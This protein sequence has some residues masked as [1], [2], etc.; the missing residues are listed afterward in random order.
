MDLMTLLAAVTF[1]GVATMF[2]VGD[3]VRAVERLAPAATVAVR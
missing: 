1:L 2:A 3:Y